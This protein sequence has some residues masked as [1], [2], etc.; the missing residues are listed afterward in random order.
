MINKGDEVEI[1][2]LGSTFKT[3]LTGI[4]MST[5]QYL[6]PTPTK[7]LI[8]MFHKELERVGVITF[9]IFKIA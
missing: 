8:E 3:T 4:G 1:V 7:V 2:G 5:D 9:Q 6:F